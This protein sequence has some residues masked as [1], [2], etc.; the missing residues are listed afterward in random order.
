MSATLSLIVFWFAALLLLAA[1]LAWIL[2][3]VFRGLLAR[4]RLDRRDLNI[5]VYRDQYREL[6][7]D[8]RNGLISDEQRDAA[9]AELEMR[10]AED[11]LGAE[12]E[13]SRPA[14]DTRRM[15]FALA[16][17]IPALA[18][19]GYLAVGEPGFIVKVA[20]AEEAEQ[21]RQRKMQE[22]LQ[23]LD[24]QVDQAL[25]DLEQAVRENP[26]DGVSWAFLANAYIARDRWEDAESAYARAYGL[27]PE[28]AVV[29]S[30]YAE[31]IAV[32]AGRDLD[33][34]PMELIRQ[35]L[36][37]DPEDQKALE[38][39]GIHAY[40]NEEF[41]T[42]AYYWNQALGQ[43]PEGS[44]AHAELT[45][46]VRGARVRG[47]TEAFGGAGMLAAPASSISGIVE[48]SA[49]LA[50]QVQPDDIVYLFARTRGAGAP[51]AT[52]STRVDQLPVD[53]VIDDGLV[54]DPEHLLSNY[55][56]ITLVARVSRDGDSRARPGDL[57]G[58]LDTVDVG[59]RG[60]RLMIDTVR[61]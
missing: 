13:P 59:S 60:I 17:V 30:G 39:A 55:E 4:E 1:V 10:L 8:H 52:L 18:C 15:G 47:H 22:A 23:R 12:S 11:A 41:T 37:I 53:F 35:A 29:L 14:R 3:S 58:A 44:P 2:P 46:M 49:D 56:S 48:I 51:I 5:A 16:G 24:G 19:A 45:A 9:R 61:P 38:L 43:M 54:T 31:T 28:K 25:A 34:R 21:E 33:G 27:L 32:N 57:E 26:E 36:Q 6:E 7:E 50:A 20:A 40:Q 42:A